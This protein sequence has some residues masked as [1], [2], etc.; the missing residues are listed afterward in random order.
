MWWA[1][2]VLLL[3]LWT[4]GMLSSYTL[5]GGIHVLLFLACAPV[6]VRAVHNWR[7]T[8]RRAGLLLARKKPE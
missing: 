5:G 1:V 8:A 6:F 7:S 4:F 2:G 3:V